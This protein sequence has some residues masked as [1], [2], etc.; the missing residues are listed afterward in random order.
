MRCTLLSIRPGQ[1]FRIASLTS[2]SR[3]GSVRRSAQNARPGSRMA[4]GHYVDTPAMAWH[5]LVHSAADVTA[6]VLALPPA[7][8]TRRACQVRRQQGNVARSSRKKRR[9][10]AT[11]GFVANPTVEAEVS[12]PGLPDDV[13]V[14]DSELAPIVNST[15][16]PTTTANV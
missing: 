11:L 14:L 8:E 10:T 15:G 7:G 12:E 5:P 1:K 3:S 9:W 4:G 16:T 6:R 13:G 2:P